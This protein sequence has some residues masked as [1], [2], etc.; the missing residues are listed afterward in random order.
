MTGQDHTCN[1]FILVF[2]EEIINEILTYVL[3]SQTIYFWTIKTYLVNE[4]LFFR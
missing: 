1:W 4:I 2:G 3:N